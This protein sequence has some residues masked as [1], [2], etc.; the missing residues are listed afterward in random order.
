M[1]YLY[2]LC[3]VSK[4]VKKVVYQGHSDEMLGR[5]HRTSTCAPVLATVL[6]KPYK[7]VKYL[8]RLSACLSARCFQMDREV[9]CTD[10]GS[11]PTIIYMYGS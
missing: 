9:E 6:H 11:K 8:D 1:E 3:E 4:G 10:L 2:Y 5:P 7:P